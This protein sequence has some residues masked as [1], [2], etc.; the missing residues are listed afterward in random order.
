MEDLSQNSADS[1]SHRQEGSKSTSR[2]PTRG[3]KIHPGLFCNTRT[4]EEEPDGPRSAV[5]PSTR[6]QNDCESPIKASSS[7][8]HSNLL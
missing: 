2:K 5:T 4:G 6:Q 7:S 1:L 8:K 3:P